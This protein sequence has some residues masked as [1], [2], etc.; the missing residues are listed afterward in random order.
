MDY[1]EQT[2]VIDRF[3]GGFAVCEDQI[4]EEMINIDR[5]L[6]PENAVEGMTIKKQDDFYFIDYENCILTRKLIIDK[7]KNNWTKEDEI[8]Y[9]IVSSVLDSA[10]KCSNIFN[11][12]NIYI[13]DSELINS[14]KKGNIIK[15]VDGKYILDEEKNLEV[16]NEIQKLIN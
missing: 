16:E 11:A 14:L 4:T 8:E 3:E 15:L 7:L 5:N 12:Q 2:L 6:I 13:E 9:Y 10:V 1:N